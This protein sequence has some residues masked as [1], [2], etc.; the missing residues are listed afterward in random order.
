MSPDTASTAATLLPIAAY[1]ADLVLPDGAMINLDGRVNERDEARTPNVRTVLAQHGRGAPTPLGV[2]LVH[3]R[4]FPD[5]EVVKSAIF[6]HL[7]GFY[8]LAQP[9]C[10]NAPTRQ[11][12][13]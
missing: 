5:R 3:R 11:L 6:E 13:E 7:E 12:G 1:L 10:E 8:M 2:R 4:R 9:I